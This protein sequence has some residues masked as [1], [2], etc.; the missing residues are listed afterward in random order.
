MTTALLSAIIV[1]AQVVETVTGFGAT[2]IALALGVH[3]VPLETLV[4]ALVLVGLLQSAWLVARGFRH[5]VWRLLLVRVI[6]ACAVGMAAGRLLFDVIGS[7]RLKIVLGVFV[8]LVAAVELVRLFRAPGDPARFNAPVGIALLAGGGFFHGLFASGGPLVVYFMSREITDK[9]AFRATL[10]V[11]WLL[12][13]LVLLATWIPGGRVTGVH[14][15]LA[16]MLLP[17]L[18]GGILLGE[19]VHARVNEV[20][21][22]RTVQ[23]VLLFTGVFLIF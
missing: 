23:V 18:A 7:G 4:V 9:R 22:K 20:V 14:L 3:L 5:V 15:L 17:A 12:L 13:N 21:F 6:P 11:L 2:V 16:A 10:S 8:A 19:L 1:A